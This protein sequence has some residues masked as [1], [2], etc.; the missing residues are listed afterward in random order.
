MSSS[1]RLLVVALALPVV[2]GGCGDLDDRTGPGAPLEVEGAWRATAYVLEAAD[3]RRVDL[4]AQTG[5]TVRLDIQADGALSGTVRVNQPG[6][7]LVDIVVS[8]SRAGPD[9]S[10]SVELAPPVLIGEVR[11]LHGPIVE[12]YQ[13]NALTWRFSQAR[14]DFDFDGPAPA[15][16]VEGTLELTRVF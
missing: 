2:L 10:P 4:V 15:E 6:T 12:Q 11:I 8:G 1:S 16:A 7:G 9:A 3:G 14:W 5:L 13:G